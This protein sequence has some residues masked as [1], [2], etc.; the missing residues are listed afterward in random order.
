MANKIFI[1]TFISSVDYNPVRV[2]PHIYF[3]NGLKDCEPYYIQHY[4]NDTK[5][6]VTSSVQQSFPYF[7]YYDG[8]VPDASSNSLL[9][10]NEQPAYGTTPTASLYTEYWD[11]Y[12]SLLYNPKTRL[13]DTSAII[14]LADYFDMELNDI[15]EWRG[16]NYHLR[17][18]N[19]YNLVDGTCKLQLL[20]PIIK[21]AISNVVLDCD[22]NF[23]SSF[24]ALTPT[25]T[26][27]V[28]PTTTTIAPTT[29]TA[30]PYDVEYLMIAGGGGGGSRHAGGG[31]A[32]GYITGSTSITPSTTYSFVI[33]GGGNGSVGLGVG[34][35]GNNSTAFSLTG[36]GG[37]SGGYGTAAGTQDGFDGGS[38]GG[39]G[40]DVTLP[41]T[42]GGNAISGE[43]N[44]GGAG[45]LSQGNFAAA[46]GGG[47]A[48]QVGGSSISGAVISNLPAD[49][50]NGTTWLDGIARAGGG[51]GGY[52]GATDGRYGAGGI[53]GGGDGA[54]AVVQSATAGQINRGAGGGGAGSTNDTAAAGGSGIVILRYLGTQRG[55]GGTITSSGGYTY[56][57]FTSS[58]TYTG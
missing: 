44:I 7:D 57:T 16:N 45:I 40:G 5:T 43:G 8:L 47:G 2:L 56:H 25:T 18:I 1:P 30:G 21:D 52:S 27:T 50:G 34:T 20:G 10:F 48:I 22:F 19:D 55:T 23:S 53:G 33:G 11:T 12:V 29:T 39:G 37:G 6:A 54:A 41:G 26:T 4:T 36:T 42:D 28:A 51:G 14:P 49:G 35:Q 32:G 58:G 9:F 3:F 46:G 38:G 17:A 24:E 31:G 13:I 15:V